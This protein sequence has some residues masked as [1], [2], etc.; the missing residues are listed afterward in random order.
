[1]PLKFSLLAY[2]YIL[3]IEFTREL[4]ANK[5]NKRSILYLACKQ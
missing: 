4:I 3:F 2:N 5:L 1:M